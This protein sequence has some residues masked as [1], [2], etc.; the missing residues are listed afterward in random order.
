ML[1]LYLSHQRRRQKEG[2]SVKCWRRF[3]GLSGSSPET[4]QQFKF[5]P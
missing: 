4:D 5:K 2:K 1:C 3:T